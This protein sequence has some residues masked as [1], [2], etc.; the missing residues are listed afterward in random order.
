MGPPISSHQEPREAYFKSSNRDH[1]CDYA[2]IH[3]IT[4]E[5]RPSQTLTSR[6]HGRKVSR[7]LRRR[8]CCRVPPVNI[9]KRRR[10]QGTRGTRGAQGAQGAQ[11]EQFRGHHFLQKSLHGAPRAVKM[12]RSC[13]QK[14]HEAPSLYTA[15]AARARNDGIASCWD[16]APAKPPRPT[17][18]SRERSWS[19]S[20][21]TLPTAPERHRF[22]HNATVCPNPVSMA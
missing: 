20:T 11:G 9:A 2:R 15:L 13:T 19:T 8:S 3:A 10:T 16:L 21:V 18:T 17:L 22:R 12:L 4:L 7:R 14:S 5:M 1:V 6:E